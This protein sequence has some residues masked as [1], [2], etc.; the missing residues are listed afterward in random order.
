MA[1]SGSERDLEC[2][3]GD[4]VATSPERVAIRPIGE[5]VGVSSDYRL[6]PALSARLVGA[7]LVLTAALVLVTTV[8]VAAVHASALVIG[9]VALAGLAVTAYV[10]WLAFRRPVVSLDDEGYRVRVIRGVGVAAAMWTEVDTA[11]AASPQGQDSVVLTLRDGRTT[12]IPA[13][14]VAGDPNAFVRDLRDH[15]QRGQ[16]LRPLGS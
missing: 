1:T 6:A 16:G 11:V 10:A 14:A 15:L 5:N 9:V 2:R 8:V 7:C 4:P 13:A 3:P 12:V